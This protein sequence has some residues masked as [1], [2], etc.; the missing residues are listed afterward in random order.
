MVHTEG[1]AAFLMR[2]PIH[3]FGLWL[4]RLVSIACD[5]SCDPAL[6]VDGAD[7]NTDDR[8]FQLR[9]E[10]TGPGNGR[11][12][13]ITYSATDASGNA[14]QAVTTVVVPHDKGKGK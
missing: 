9:A 4:V 7:L 12:Y 3:N 10:R 5:D 11:T 1:Y 6:D 8:E 14:A 2:A 13:T